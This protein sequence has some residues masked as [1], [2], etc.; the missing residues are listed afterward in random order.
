VL[1]IC[2]LNGYLKHVFHTLSFRKTEG[3]AKF[4]SE[5]LAGSPD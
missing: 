4:G 1:P 5:N 3:K 2:F